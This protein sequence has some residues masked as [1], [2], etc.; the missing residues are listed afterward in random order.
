MSVAFSL[1]VSVGMVI[2]VLLMLR[3]GKLR[4]KYAILWL[5][6]GGL[7]IILGV[8]PGLLDW[9][10]SV[11]GIKVPANLLFALSIVLLVGV[12]LHVSRELTVL[13]E[14]TRT[15]AEEVAILRQ[16][17]DSVR[18]T[19]APAPRRSPD[20][21]HPIQTARQTTPEEVDRDH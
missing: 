3:S 10:A 14:E 16:T 20:S 13:E 4:E 15:L 18:S 2:A 17:I 5:V 11:V 6:V 8:F 7:T 1:V 12:G 21:S 9:A 19:S